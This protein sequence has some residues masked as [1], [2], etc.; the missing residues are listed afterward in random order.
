MVLTLDLKQ[1]VIE[2]ALKTIDEMFDKEV[3]RCEDGGFL[4]VI[5]IEIKEGK[6]Q[7]GYYEK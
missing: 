3:G 7:E 4:I 1:R 6:K 5:K 2:S